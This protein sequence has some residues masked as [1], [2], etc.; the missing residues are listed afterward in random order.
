[1]RCRSRPATRGALSRLRARST[2]ALADGNDQRARAAQPGR[3]RQ[4]ARD[5][6]V[7]TEC[8]LRGSCAANR[9][10][11]T[12][13]VVDPTRARSSRDRPHRIVT[14]AS[15]RRTSQ[16]RDARRR[17]A[18]PRRRRSR[19]APPPAASGRRRSRCVCRTPRSG[20]ARTSASAALAPKRL[21]KPSLDALH[22]TPRATPR[23]GR[24]RR[25]RQRRSS[26]RAHSRTSH[27]ASLR[28]DRARCR[29]AATD[30][31]RR[32][33]AGTTRNRTPRDTARP[34]AS[35]SSYSPRGDRGT[36]RHAGNIERRSAT[37][38]C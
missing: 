25:A 7:D 29:P 19:A 10:T 11:T 14:C 31:A 24:H 5:R 4:I 9:R 34:T 35:G 18:A 2:S 33:R 26:T 32:P 20:R 12:C 8:A 21:A 17:R 1:M 15:R 28:A 27:P 16:H 36:S 23:L 30:R 6:Q 38:S 13:D 3:A 22:Q 37:R